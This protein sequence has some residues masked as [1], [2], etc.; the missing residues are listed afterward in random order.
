MKAR[1]KGG[2]PANDPQR[3]R[4]WTRRPTALGIRPTTAWHDANDKPN[5]VYHD[6]A[7]RS[8]LV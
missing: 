4:T 5:H 2:Y 1:G 8:L 3:P 6:E 7:I